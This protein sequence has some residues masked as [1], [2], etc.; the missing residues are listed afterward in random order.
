MTDNKRLRQ[1][2]SKFATGI[3]IITIVDK[4]QNPYGVTVNSFG[5]L[6]L[7]PA[8]V[9]WSLGDQT[10]ALEEF[11]QSDYFVV[12]VLDAQQQDV[13]NNFAMQGEFDRFESI[14]YTVNNK[15]IPVI[16]DCIASFFCSQFKIDRIGDHWLFIAQ[17]DAFE[18]SSGNPLIY[19]NSDYQQLV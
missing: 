8:L 14:S 7:D 4:Q 16:N 2:L 6:S 15:N 12:N 13:S 5:S 17:V 10:Y 1:A 3:T 11:L 19:Y 9:L 18:F